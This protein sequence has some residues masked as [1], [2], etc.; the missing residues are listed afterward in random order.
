[1]LTDHNFD[2]KSW[3]TRSKVGWKK[4][5]QQIIFGVIGYFTHQNNLNCVNTSQNLINRVKSKTGDGHVLIL[6]YETLTENGQ[7][8]VPAYANF[9]KLYHPSITILSAAVSVYY[10]LTRDLCVLTLTRILSNM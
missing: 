6:C 2:N 3:W 5:E 4:P 7:L 9:P 1:M 10:I 8:G